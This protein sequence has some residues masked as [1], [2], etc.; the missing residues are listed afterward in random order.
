MPGMTSITLQARGE[1]HPNLRPLNVLRDL[2]SVA[3]LVELC[4][5]NT[6]DND[7]RNYVKQMRD[8]GR[9]SYFLSWANKMTETASLPLSG[10]VWEE[11]SKIVGN[12]S[13]IPFRHNKQKIYLIANVAAHPDYR[14]RGIARA[15]TERS[16]QNARQKKADSIWLHVRDDNPGAVKL[17]LDLGF[18]ERARRTTWQANTD[19]LLSAPETGFNITGRS[20]HFWLQQR[21]WL[22]RL[23]PDEL[24]WHHNW[25]WK[26]L[27]PG[28]WNWLYR[29][30]VEAEIRQWAALKN[31]TLQAVLSWMPIGGR[32]TDPLWMAMNPDGDETALK[33]LLLTARKELSY[34][35]YLSLEYP[36]GNA[37]EAIRSA[38]FSA[39]RTLLWMQAPGATS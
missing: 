25:N 10:F 18:V 31:G 30:F 34:R 12:A 35:R 26:S 29:L 5:S 13:L 17:Y 15:L 19:P 8:A 33:V 32:Y 22:Q 14:R 9:D 16:M 11:N 39:Q 7:G 21:E 37:V 23:H 2:P 1:T 20:S 27:E 4:F 3:D 24:A 38:G 28:L 36:A 6:M